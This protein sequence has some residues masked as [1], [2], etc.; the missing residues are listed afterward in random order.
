MHVPACVC[1]YTCACVFVCVCGLFALLFL[2]VL[3]LHND[4]E[5]NTLSVKLGW[6]FSFSAYGETE[7]SLE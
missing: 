2:F 3:N 4:S 6:I 5:Y 7:P 1:M